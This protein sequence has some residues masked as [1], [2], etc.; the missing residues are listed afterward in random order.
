MPPLVPERQRHPRQLAR[1]NR[2]LVPKTER[3]DGLERIADFEGL[4]PEG[5][6]GAGPSIVWDF[7]T[8]RNLSEKNGHEIPIEQ[9]LR[10]LRD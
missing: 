6:Y 10:Q 8:Y 7:G 4:I 2:L 9:A 3:F 1:K 5:E